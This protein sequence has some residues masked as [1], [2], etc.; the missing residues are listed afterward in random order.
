M[1]GKIKYLTANEVEELVPFTSEVIK[2]MAKKGAFPRPVMFDSN[3]LWLKNEVMDWIR[4]KIE[5]IEES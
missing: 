2:D 5:Y 4:S 1:D 3:I